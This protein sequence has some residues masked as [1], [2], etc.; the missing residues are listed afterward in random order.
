MA[1]CNTYGFM[2]QAQMSTDRAVYIQNIPIKSK[3]SA[4]E[5][6]KKPVSIRLLEDQYDQG[7]FWAKENNALVLHRDRVFTMEGCEKIWYHCFEQTYFPVHK[8]TE[9]LKLNIQH[10]NPHIVFGENAKLEL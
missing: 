1:D 10:H 2:P 7:L 6:C 9:L 8:V 5:A 4:E 3:I